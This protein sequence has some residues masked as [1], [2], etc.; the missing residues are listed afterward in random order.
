[1]KKIGK[2]LLCFLPL[3][4]FIA[5]Q[6]VLG[7][8]GGIGAGFVAGFE[9][10]MKGMGNDVVYITQR[11]Q[12]MIA[13]VNPIVIC[14]CHVLAVV[15]GCI[16]V[17]YAFGKKKPGNPVKTFSW[18]TL[19]VIVL[20]AI[21]LQYGSSAALGIVDKISPALMESY[22]QLMESAGLSSMNVLTL[23]ASVCL[24]PIGE[25]LLFRGVTL[26]YAKNAGLRFWVA[27]IIQ[28]VCF[29]IAHLNIVQGCY[30]FVL[31]IVLGYLYEKYN[32]LYVPILV[33]FVFNL[34]GTVVSYVLQALLGESIAETSE[35]ALISYIIA[36]VINAAVLALGIIL[37]RKDKKAC[38]PVEDKGEGEY[39]TL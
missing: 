15:I 34:L 10:G 25:E 38:Q 7:L 17:Y 35:P 3:I 5:I 6:V 28:A 20:C 14:A 37:I 13:I 29:G 23:I 27:N 2:F 24:A 4:A 36:L 26:R 22:N 21:G 32:S 18:M 16:W 31:G 9:A 12:E 33:H 11:T 30:A 19:L 1:M 39:A 8:I